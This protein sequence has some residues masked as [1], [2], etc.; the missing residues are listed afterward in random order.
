MVLSG[1]AIAEAHDVVWDA[2]LGVDTAGVEC[3]PTAYHVLR[4]IL[5][6]VDLQPGDRFVDIGC[7][8]GRVLCLAALWPIAHVAG[9]ELRGEHAAAAERNLTRLRGRKTKSF[10][11]KSGSAEDFDVS[12]GTVYYLYNPFGGALLET[13]IGR[14]RDGMKGPIRLVYVN[15][16]NRDIVEKGG[17]L[18][19]PE[20]AYKDRSGKDAALMYRSR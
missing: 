18:N 10:F 4:S 8:R 16:Q 17:W 5:S 7:G 13:I 19:E 3:R 15:P 1:M 11:V 6:R 2:V 9:V 14:I 12:G 20:V